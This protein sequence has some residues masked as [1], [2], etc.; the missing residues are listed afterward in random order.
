LDKNVFCN[1]KPLVLRWFDVAV[2]KI[3]DVARVY[4]VMIYH[5]LNPLAALWPWG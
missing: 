3:K 2:L 5:S 4:S 1:L